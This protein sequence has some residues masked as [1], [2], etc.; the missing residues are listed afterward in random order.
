M[1]EQI[2]WST[3][4]DTYARRKLFSF[5][6]ENYQG[7]GLLYLEG[8]YSG[9]KANHVLDCIT[10]SVAS[11]LREVV[12][13]LYSALVIPNLE[14]YVQ[15]W[16]P[17]DKKHMDLLEKVQKRTTELIT[18]LQH[19]PHEDKLRELRLFSLEKRRLQGDLIAP[20]ST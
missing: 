19:L 4:I 5:L 1:L 2:H 20:Y 10:R 18:G 9:Q 13:P 8:P 14:Y 3:L 15:V 16:G 7:S 12:L 17:Q 6:G 11:M